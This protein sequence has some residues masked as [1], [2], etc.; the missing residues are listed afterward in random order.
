MDGDKV[1]KVRQLIAAA[2]NALDVSAEERDSLVNRTS[3]GAVAK[4]SL[5]SRMDSARQLLL[6]AVEVMP[7]VPVK[8]PRCHAVPSLTFCKEYHRIECIGTGDPSFGCGIAGPWHRVAKDAIGLWNN[9]A[10]K[11]EPCLD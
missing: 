2:F 4:G 11:I 7:W 10:E 9:F 3:A 6:E 8:C 1:K 5:V